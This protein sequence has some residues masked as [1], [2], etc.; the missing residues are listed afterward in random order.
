VLNAIIGNIRSHMQYRYNPFESKNLLVIL[1]R[2]WFDSRSRERYGWKY[3]QIDRL[4]PFTKSI[5]W[6]LRGGRICYMMRSLRR[7]TRN[8][9]LLK[10]LEKPL[11]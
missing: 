4:L 2:Y 1:T 11:N 8:L 6:F 10:L 5:I 7:L 9:I 3:L